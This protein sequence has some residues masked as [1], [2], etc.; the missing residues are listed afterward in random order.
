M[1]IVDV[2]AAGYSPGMDG[3]T[4]AYLDGLRRELAALRDAMGML[5]EELRGD[6]SAISDELGDELARREVRVREEL[7]ATVRSEVRGIG[8]GVG[9]NAA[10]VDELGAHVTR[11]MDERFAA[12]HATLRHL[13][14]DIDE[15]RCDGLRDAR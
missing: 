8:D 4:R 3:E 10:A 12:V 15:L 5:R 9:R 14:R 6:M 7:R 2:R 11:E 1:D 13:R